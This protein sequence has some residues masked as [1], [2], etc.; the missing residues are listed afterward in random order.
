M[1]DRASRSARVATPAKSWASGG[2]GG[3]A[4]GARDLGAL[5]GGAATLIQATRELWVGK[6]GLRLEVVECAI[7]LVETRLHES[8]V[9]RAGAARRWPGEGLDPVDGQKPWC[10]FFPGG[11][12][13]ATPAPVPRVGDQGRSHRIQDDVATDLEKVGLP[14]DELRAESALQDVS[15]SIVGPIEPLCVYPV[16][17][18]HRSGEVALRRLQQH[19]IVIAHQAVGVATHAI[20]R[21]HRGQ[22]DQEERAVC[23]VLEDGLPVIAPRGDVIDTTGERQPERSRHSATLPPRPPCLQVCRFGYIPARKMSECKT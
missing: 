9:G 10:R 15:A 8:H 17:L 18:P 23:I 5:R 13:E 16:Q 1:T 12:A 6:L 20:A 4:L 3:K 11:R 19:V 21:D 7:S 2:A 22:D 14:V